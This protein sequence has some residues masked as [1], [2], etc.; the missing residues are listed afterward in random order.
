MCI[1]C[2]NA[3]RL[4]TVEPIAIT[5]KQKKWA[6]VGVLHNARELSIRVANKL[7]N[8]RVGTLLSRMTNF[9]NTLQV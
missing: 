8:Y 4:H 9:Q 6:C 3:M 2:A 1:M 7:Q 5:I